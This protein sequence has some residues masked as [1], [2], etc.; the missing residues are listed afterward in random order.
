MCF[1]NNPLSLKLDMAFDPLLN[2]PKVC[3]LMAV[4]NGAQWLKTQVDSIVN[5]NG[6]EVRI[7]IS[8]DYST[9]D[10]LDMCNSLANSYDCITVLPYGD[11]FDGPAQN[12]FRLV[13]DVNFDSCDYISFLT[14]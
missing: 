9:D 5:Q 12:F 7:F 6:V 1:L 4:C 11:R 2:C 13:K 3:V 10:S 8:V 14:R